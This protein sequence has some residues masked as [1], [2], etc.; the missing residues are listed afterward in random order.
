[1]IWYNFSNGRGEVVMKALS[2]PASAVYL[3]LV[4]VINRDLAWTMRENLVICAWFKADMMIWFSARYEVK[5]LSNMTLIFAGGVEFCQHLTKVNPHHYVYNKN[6]FLI[7]TELNNFILFYKQMD[8]CS[9]VW[10]KYTPS[11]SWTLFLMVCS[12]V[13]CIYLFLIDCLRYLYIL[14]HLSLMLATISWVKIHNICKCVH[15]NDVNYVQY[16]ICA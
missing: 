9:I 10:D 5:K 2:S 3:R 8:I 12:T 7:V 13:W 1:M 11:I 15:L 16:L 6:N 14:V 4:A